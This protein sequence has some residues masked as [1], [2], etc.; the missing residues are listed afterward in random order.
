MLVVLE[1]VEAGAGWGQQ[2]DVAGYGRYTGL[3]D[4]VL[5]SLGMHD[6]GFNLGFDFRRRSADRIDALD[7]LSKQFIEDGVV[8]TFVLA[9]EDEVNVRGKRFQS[10]DGRIDVGGLGIVVVVSRCPVGSRNRMFPSRTQV[11]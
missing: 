1:L 11:P 8:A 6:L 7:P 9:A 10:L 4:G 2:D 3:A 5:Q